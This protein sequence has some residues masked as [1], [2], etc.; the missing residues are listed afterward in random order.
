MLVAGADS[1]LD[2]ALFFY[3]P[4]D[5][6]NGEAVDLPTLQLVRGKK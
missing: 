4:D 1:G 6:A 5:P 3:D 2:G